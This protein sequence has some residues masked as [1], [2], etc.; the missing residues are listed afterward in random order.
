[1]IELPSASM[2]LP[3]VAPKPVRASALPLKPALMI[4][5]EPAAIVGGVGATAGV[6]PWFTTSGSYTWTWPFGARMVAS[7]KAPSVPP[8][9]HEHPSPSCHGVARPAAVSGLAGTVSVQSIVLSACAAVWLKLNGLPA[10]S[11]ALGPSARSP[12]V[13]PP[14]LFRNADWL[15]FVEP[16]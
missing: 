12:W 10:A 5:C 1:M 13:N 14:N 8:L 6:L 7:T 11:C 2:H 16:E 3:C 9:A 4:T 15:T